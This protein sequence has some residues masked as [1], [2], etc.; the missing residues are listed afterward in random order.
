M[1]IHEYELAAFIP[2]DLTPEEVD[3]YCKTQMPLERGYVEEEDWKNFKEK[4][5]ELYN[6]RISESIK[7]CPKTGVDC[8]PSITIILCK[9]ECPYHTLHRK[10]RDEK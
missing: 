9:D 6:S 4:I 7:K 5:I 2:D 10:A 3:E 1:G 8:V